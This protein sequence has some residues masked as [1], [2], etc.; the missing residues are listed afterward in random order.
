MKAKKQIVKLTE[1]DFSKMVRES[2]RRTV[3]E[4]LRMG[5]M[6]LNECGGSSGGCGGGSSSR[7]SGG[8]GGGS[9]RSSGCGGGSGIRGGCGYTG[10]SRSTC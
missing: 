2:V 9:R 3:L 5:K 4:T 8:C 1:S 7:S 10:R 6:N